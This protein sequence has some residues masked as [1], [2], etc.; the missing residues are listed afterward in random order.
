M[1]NPDIPDS[2]IMSTELYKEY[3]KLKKDPRAFLNE[4]IDMNNTLTELVN[5]KTREISPAIFHFLLRQQLITSNNFYDF[6][7]NIMTNDYKNDSDLR[8]FP[9]EFNTNTFG[10]VIVEIPGICKNCGSNDK[11]FKCPYKRSW[12]CVNCMSKCL[13]CKT[14][15]SNMSIKKCCCCSKNVCTFC[16]LKYTNT[17]ICKKCVKFNK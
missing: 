15:C 7:K 8:F 16:R 1:S 4:S 3:Q 9:E 2:I 11:T 10:R 17:V 12:Y 13:F 14:I 5:R 6:K